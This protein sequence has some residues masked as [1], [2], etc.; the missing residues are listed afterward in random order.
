[1]TGAGGGSPG[2]SGNI[3]LIG[4][5]GTGKSTVA[6]LVAKRLGAPWSALDLDIELEARAGRSITRVFEEEGEA[7]FRERERLLLEEVA[8]FERRVVATGGGIIGMRENRDRLRCGFV[9]WLTAVPESISRR[10]DLDH[11]TIRSRP[12]LTARG[13]LEEIRELL[14]AREPY[15]RELARLKLATDTA[16]PA[17]LAK[18][19]ADA[20]RQAG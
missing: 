13:G 9:V 14:A 8:A 3:Y 20:F 2:I 4:Y 19:V 10:L 7:G 12:N 1:M 16:S 5:R 17:E 6:P 18:A 15:Y 11:A